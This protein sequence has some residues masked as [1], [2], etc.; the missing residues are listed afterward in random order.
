MLAKLA[1]TN[2]ALLL[3]SGPLHLWSQI[4]QL[5][6]K[7]N[8]TCR[9]GPPSLR[10][11]QVSTQIRAM[12]GLESVTQVDKKGRTVEE[13]RPSSVS[14]SRGPGVVE[15]RTAVGCVLHK[16]EVHLMSCDVIFMFRQET[17]ETHTWTSNPG[18]ALRPT[19]VAWGR[20]GSDS[21]VD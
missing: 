7:G 3:N 5:N 18:F 13:E 19:D 9:P 11:S 6:S 1:Q 20:S 12:C 21:G 16:K 14:S 17:G 10:A 15:K 8:P 2:L 4:K